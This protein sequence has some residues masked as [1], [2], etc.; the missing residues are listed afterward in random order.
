MQNLSR[1]Y[2]HKDIGR[3]AYNQD[4][5]LKDHRVKEKQYFKRL[6][7]Y[8]IVNYRKPKSIKK[9]Y[10]FSLFLC[11]GRFFGQFF[12]TLYMKTVFLSLYRVPIF[13]Q[14]YLLVI[15]CSSLEAI[16]QVAKRNNQ[17]FG[18]IWFDF[19]SFEVLKIRYFDAKNFGSN[20]KFIRLLRTPT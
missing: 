20:K 15:Q 11:A 7:V 6:S 13:L 10:L 17:I 1:F 8:I 9:T 16:H 3:W 4:V 12:Y 14:Q 18:V 5:L 19:I 2:A